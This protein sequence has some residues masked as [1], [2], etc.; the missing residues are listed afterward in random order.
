MLWIGLC[1]RVAGRTGENGVVGG[2]RVAIAAELRCVVRNRKPSVIE[3][4]AG[5]ARGRVTRGAGGGETCSH[6]IRIRGPGVVRFVTGVA[7][8]WS[9][10]ELAIDMAART[11]HGQVCAS[12]RKRGVGMIKSAVRP[13]DCVVTG[14]ASRWKTRRR[15]IRVGRSRVVC[16]VTGVAVS[17]CPRELPINVTTAAWNCHVRARERKDCF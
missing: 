2:I 14:R 6:V 13:F 7:V 9:T 10:G 3:G 8:A 12:Q 1:L 16:L 15:V 11:R 17:R 4:R 5:P